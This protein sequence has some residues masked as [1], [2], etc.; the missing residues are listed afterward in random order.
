[1]HGAAQRGSS[2]RLGVP[3]S[4]ARATMAAN[5]PPFDV[6]REIITRV[7]SPADLVSLCLASTHMRD[8]CGSAVHGVAL[9][10]CEIPVSQG[11]PS[12]SR[13]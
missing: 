9:A 2:L 11:F 13:V 8:A 3:R 6:M 4:P 12:I 1:M 7:H 5:A 10:R